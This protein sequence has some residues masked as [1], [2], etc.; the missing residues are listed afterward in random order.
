MVLVW[1]ALLLDS[2]FAISAEVGRMDL[3]GAIPGAVVPV[4]PEALAL[5]TVTE[6]GRTAPIIAAAPLGRGRIVAFGHDA[7]TAP[8]DPEAIKA[9]RA[10]LAWAARNP[11]P[12]VAFRGDRIGVWLR[13]QGLEAVEWTDQIPAADVILCDGYGPAKGVENFL[14]QGGGLVVG[15]TPWGWAMTNPGKSMEKDLEFG[16]LLEKAGLVFADGL[17]DADKLQPVADAESARKVNA[18][19]AVTEI[20]NGRFDQAEIL[21][22]ALSGLGAEHP[23]RRRIS[24]WSQSRPAPKF[25]VKDAG[26]RLK[27]AIDWRNW[28]AG[29]RAPQG[30]FDFPGDVPA[31]AATVSRVL[32]VNPQPG[33]WV[34]TGLYAAPNAR[35]RLRTE[36]KGLAVQIG[37]H[38]DEN[39]HHPEWLRHPNVLVRRPIAQ[40]TTAVSPFGGLL[41]VF[42]ESGSVAPAEVTIEGAVPAPRFARGKTTLE[43]WRRVRDLPGPWAEIG[44]DK[45]IVTVPSEAIRQLDNPEAVAALWDRTIDL[46][47]ELDGAPLPKFPERMVADRQISAGYMHAGYPIMTF[48]DVTDLVTNVNKL[49]TEGSWGHWHELGHN[50]QSRDWT[51]EGT[52]E[53]TV[54]LYTLW[55][56]KHFANR[57]LWDRLD[58]RIQAQARAHR[59][60]GAPFAKWKEDPFLALVMYAELIDGF[61]WETLKKVLRDY[62]NGPRPR[63]DDEKRDQ[64]MVRYARITG[65]NLGP[66]FQA[67]GVPTSESARRSIAG[68]PEWNPANW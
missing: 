32:S 2:P 38:S 10:A 39:W 58:A 7:W 43:E 3:G 35:I 8:G 11:R 67:W 65:R 62:Q 68:L 36:A 19:A 24:R 34:S 27:L 21:T 54:N 46:F 60:A 5:W 53:V 9:T 44:S 63:S 66:F 13:G 18:E 6:N 48:L 14:R 12:R 57:G 61:G 29:G 40:D 20:E 31:G 22:M 28:R 56:M 25:P 41:Y 59:A 16:R 49:T 55:A 4:R 52:G 50:R 33:E 15:A 64:W 30:E 47:A 26:D 1:A 23:I 42:R 51:F 45:V 37:V 17:Y